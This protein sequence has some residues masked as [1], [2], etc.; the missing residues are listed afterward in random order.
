MPPR[1]AAGHECIMHPHCKGIARKTSASKTQKAG[2][3]KTGNNFSLFSSFFAARGQGRAAAA[4]RNM[5]C[6][7]RFHELHR[8]DATTASAVAALRGAHLRARNR[9]SRSGR[10]GREGPSGQGGAQRDPPPCRAHRASRWRNDARPHCEKRHAVQGGPSS[11]SA[12]TGSR[13]HGALQSW[14]MR[15]RTDG[16]VH[17]DAAARSGSRPEW[18]P[19]G[20]TTQYSTTHCCKI[21]VWQNLSTAPSGMFNK[22]KRGSGDN[23]KSVHTNTH[24]VTSA[25]I[26]S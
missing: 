8:R 13:M 25:E 1:H 4:T 21:T 16:R 17:M 14:S 5:P 7:S 3:C 12:S 10:E 26:F 9:A 15:T 20:S 18:Q 24:H 23:L 6:R 22:N 19:P 2:E 11:L